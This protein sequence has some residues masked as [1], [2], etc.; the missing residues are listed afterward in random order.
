LGFSFVAENPAQPVTQ[1]LAAAR[2]GGEDA[3]AQLLDL[4]YAELHSIAG[5]HMAGVPAGDTL[6]PTALVHE[7]YLR[8]FGGGEVPWED[9][10]HFFFSAGRVMRDIVIEQARRHASAKR[11][12]GRLRVDLDD[13]IVSTREQAT[14]LM[15]LDEALRQLEATDATSAQVVM[16]RYFAGL[17]VPETARAMGISPATVDRN[18]RYAR[19]WLR[20]R[21]HGDAAGAERDRSDER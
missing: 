20:G 8:L 21:L 5:R 4:V 1:L 6:Q 19:A 9:R 2:A 15:A 3:A 14:D 10:A 18:W 16:L 12:G 7:A 17:T 13:A 11:G